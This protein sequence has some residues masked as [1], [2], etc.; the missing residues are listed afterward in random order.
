LAILQNKADHLEGQVPADVL[1]FI[2]GS[3]ESNIRELEGALNQVLAL[4]V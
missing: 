3:V 4:T 1:T 2:A